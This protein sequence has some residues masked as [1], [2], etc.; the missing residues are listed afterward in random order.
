M[1]SPYAPPQDGV[2]LKVDFVASEPFDVGATP[3]LVA[4]MDVCAERT[5]VVMN[6][7]G[8]VPARL[9][10]ENTD[11]AREGIPAV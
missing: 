10:I 9:G 11:E 2:L 3:S 4:G 6:W 8:S 1:K 5:W 7:Y